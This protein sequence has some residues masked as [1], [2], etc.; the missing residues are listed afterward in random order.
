MLGR[1]HELAAVGAVIST[2]IIFPVAD[3][4]IETATVSL[5]VALL[6][7]LTPDIDK[8]GS[9]LWANVPAGGC[10]SR[11]INPFF[12]GGHRHLTHSLLGLVIF[13]GLMRLLLEALPLGEAIDTKI[14]FISFMVAF[15][16]HI[17]T[18][19]LTKDG[20][21]LL[22]PLPLHFGFPPVEFLR[23]KTNGTAEKVIV[24]PAI[25]LL[26]GAVAYYHRENALALLQLFGAS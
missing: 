24:V 16:S 4:T 2:A 15:A 10:L 18:D 9:K 5:L 23:M 22:F 19:M 8:P 12:A 7:G 14:V 21:P 13:G 1:T 3:M 20:V 6:G 26:V 11:L 25:V 17:A